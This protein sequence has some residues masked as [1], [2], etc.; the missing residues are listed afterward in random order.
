MVKW[1]FEKIHNIDKH[2]DRLITKKREDTNYQNEELNYLFEDSTHIKKKIR[3]YYEQF[4]TN[5]FDH[6]DEIGKIF[7]SQ[8]LSKV[9]QEK[10][11][12]LNNPYN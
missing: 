12:N 8:K 9:T 11:D 4:Y 10:V 3:E 2:L 5:D 7:K 6:L 1:V